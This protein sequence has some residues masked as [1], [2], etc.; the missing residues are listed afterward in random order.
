M[1]DAHAHTSP[2]D[3]TSVCGT[4]LDRPI[5]EHICHEKQLVPV[6]L[7][8]P[9]SLDQPWAL[10][11]DCNVLPLFRL[12]FKHSPSQYV[13]T[14]LGVSKWGQKTLNILQYSHIELVQNVSSYYE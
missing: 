12:E 1:Y 9:A 2:D 8:T 6:H 13:E 7:S 5:N 10:L 4:C 11:L 14:T 3:I